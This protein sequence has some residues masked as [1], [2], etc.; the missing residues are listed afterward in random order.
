MSNEVPPLDKLV[1]VYIKMRTRIQ[2]LTREYETKIEELKQQQDEVRLAMKDQLLAI[3][4]KTVRTDSGLIILTKKTR[5]STNDWQSFKDF[6]VEHDAIDLL[7]KRIAQTN[8]QQFLEENPGL[9]P[10]G[11]NS[12]TEYDVTVK[13]PSK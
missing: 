10:P 7:E 11:L 6:I 2:E 13:K 5:Y 8:M 4:S 1:R 12:L 9:V 3:G